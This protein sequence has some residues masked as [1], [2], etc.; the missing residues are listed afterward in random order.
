LFCCDVIAKKNKEKILSKLLDLVFPHYAEG[1]AR[2]ILP[3]DFFRIE[4]IAQLVAG[5]TV[6]TGV[7]GIQLGAELGAVDFYK[8]LKVMISFHHA[9]GFVIVSRDLSQAVSPAAVGRHKS[10]MDFMVFRKSGSS[11]HHSQGR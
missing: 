7:V 5:E 2:E 3:V 11:N 9:I 1:F 6:E 8:A 10:C 4:K